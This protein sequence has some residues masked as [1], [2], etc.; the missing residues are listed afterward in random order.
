M[1]EKKRPPRRIVPR[2]ITLPA[3]TS[4]SLNYIFGRSVSGGT[5]STNGRSSLGAGCGGSST[6][7]GLPGSS[8]GAGWGV[9]LFG[10]MI[11]QL[12]KVFSVPSQDIRRSTSI[13]TM[14]RMRWRTPPGRDA[15]TGSD[16][17][18]AVAA[19]DGFKESGAITSAEGAERLRGI[20][21]DVNFGRPPRPS[22]TCLPG[23][24]ATVP[25]APNNVC[26]PT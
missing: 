12:D 8:G 19:I 3:A 25:T 26:D 14:T 11:G 20:Y 13:S 15:F 5:G 21:P 9:G 16:R 17:G 6:G 23:D 18:A 1:P 22:I 4:V 24:A 2:L 10:G 7:W